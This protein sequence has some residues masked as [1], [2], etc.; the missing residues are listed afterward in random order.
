MATKVKPE[1]KVEAAAPVQDAPAAKAEPKF[2][3]EKL[4]S[5]CVE[6]F[7][8]TSSTFDGAMYGHDLDAEYSIGEVKHI[9]DVFLNG[10]K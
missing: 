10:G 5:N 8:V 6:V 7:G 4:R 1:T 9:I 2:V 3:V